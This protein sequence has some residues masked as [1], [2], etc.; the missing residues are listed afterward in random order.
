MRTIAGKRY[1]ALYTTVRT[2]TALDM[3]CLQ[4]ISKHYNDFKGYN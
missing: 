4:N 1:M 2:L 3:S